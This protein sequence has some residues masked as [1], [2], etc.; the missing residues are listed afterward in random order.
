MGGA[1]VGYNAIDTNTQSIYFFQGN[2]HLETSY[3]SRRSPDT[4]WWRLATQ[5][6]ILKLP[7][8]ISPRQ[9]Q[10]LAELKSQGEEMQSERSATPPRSAFLHLYLD[11]MGQMCIQPPPHLSLCLS[12]ERPQKASSCKGT[13]GTVV[14]GGLKVR[15]FNR[16]PSQTTV[17]TILWEFFGGG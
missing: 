10:I 14:W 15:S 6:R 3:H 4:T 2:C 9:V 7:S 8:A 1:S 12:L 16:H 13:M 5:S 11:M 17:P